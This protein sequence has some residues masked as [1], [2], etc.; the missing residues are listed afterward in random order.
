MNHIVFMKIIFV[1]LMC[2]N[3]SVQVSDLLNGSMDILYI[4][5]ILHDI[6]LVG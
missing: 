4:V 2:F 5:Y 6:L 1:E 3:R